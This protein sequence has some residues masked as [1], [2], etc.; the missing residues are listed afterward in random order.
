M[1][2]NLEE[3]CNANN[4][5]N[6][7]V[8]AKKGVDWK[9]SVQRYEIDF[10][11]NIYKTQQSIRIGNYK[12]KPMVEFELHERGR[13]RGIKAQHISDRVVQHSLNDNVLLP[14][15]RPFLIYDNGASLKHK[16]LDFARRRFKVQLQKAYK[17]FNGNGY[18]LSID[19]SKYFD[20][21]RHDVAINQFKRFLN[22][23]ELEFVKQCFKNFEIDV[24]YL[25]ENEYKEC[26]DIIFNVLE[27]KKQPI[28]NGTKMMCKS[29]GIGNQISQ[30]TGVLYPYQ[31]DNYCKIVLSLK[32]FNRYMDDTK[33]IFPSKEQALDVYHKLETL[34][35]QLGIFVNKKKTYISKLSDWHTFLK[36]NYKVLESGRVICKV[37]ND[38][39][40]RTRKR[41]VKHKKLCDKGKMTKQEVL[42]CYKSWRG[43]Y[44]KYDS[45]YK[46]HKIDK[47]FER[48]FKMKVK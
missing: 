39:I 4:L 34:Y 14:R 11:A 3:I 37:H 47:L 43:C 9:E 6:A 44:I 16:G 7:F 26:M 36:I 38:T 13:V 48:L 5:Y 32:H 42:N 8:E 19:F 46:I 10:L 24:S 18:V 31:I 2:E 27:Y 1:N 23:Q 21:I 12:S 29:I 22:T 40:R 17:E 45:G 30:V 15:I 35:A 41:L 20:N 25:S 28:C 33:I